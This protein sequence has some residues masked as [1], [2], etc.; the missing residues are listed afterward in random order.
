MVPFVAGSETDQREM[1]ERNGG[2]WLNEPNVLGSKFNA[3]TEAA[4]RWGADFVLVLGSDDLLSPALADVYA[5]HF[6]DRTTYLGLKGCFMVEP[7]TR[8]A[9]LLKG[10]ANPKR[11]GETI[12]AGRLL[13]RRLLDKVQGRPW[14]NGLKRGA[15]LMMTIRLFTLGVAGPDVILDSDDTHFLLDVKGGG[16]L[17]RFDGVQR[18]THV[19]SP[20]DYETLIAVLPD[21]EQGVLRLLE[22]ANCPTCGHLRPW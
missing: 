18:H 19:V 2:V 22:C 12:G 7:A 8:R 14:P 11:F 1:C 9:L 15:D 21:D 17:W 3:A 16:N 20:A 13:S 6:N 5:E 10:H 4:W